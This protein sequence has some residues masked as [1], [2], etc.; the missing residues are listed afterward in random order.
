M[1][2]VPLSFVEARNNLIT[3]LGT[4]RPILSAD[5]ERG[6]SLR[7]PAQ[8]VTNPALRSLAAAGSAGL[9][10]LSPGEAR[11]CIYDYASSW[12]QLDSFRVSNAIACLDH[13]DLIVPELNRHRLS[14]SLSLVRGLIERTAIAWSIGRK[15]RSVQAFPPNLGAAQAMQKLIDISAPVRRALYGARRDWMKLA[16]A[17]LS[18]GSPPEADA[19]SVAPGFANMEAR[20]TLS[21]VDELNKQVKGVRRAYEVLCD[22]LHPNVGDLFSASVDFRYRTDR[23]GL[24]LY[25]RTL[26]LG[27]T[28]RSV[29][30]DLGKTVTNV[31][32]IASDAISRVPEIHALLQRNSNSAMII[33]QTW[34]RGALSANPKLFERDELCPCLGGARV[35]QCCGRKTEKPAAK[36]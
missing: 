36:S 34:M 12:H 35:Y 4:V 24:K 11:A 8:S 2:N 5:A 20:N 18:D 7:F 16:A 10:R 9:A 23:H 21:Y 27:P 31:L 14:L 26:G 33:T 17:E 30:L 15:T 1:S 3:V 6:T 32:T 25:C 22:F 28:D 13:V 19:Y 29:H